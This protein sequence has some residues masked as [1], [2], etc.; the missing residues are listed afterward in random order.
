MSNIVTNPVPRTWANVADH[1]ARLADAINNIL[2][3]KLNNTGAVTLTA[4]AATTTLTDSR[5]GAE[6][7]IVLQATT[8]NAAG[9]V[10]TTYLD[11]PGNGSVVINHANNS[12]TDRTF[13]YAV[14]G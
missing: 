11:A 8:A 7:A 2:K 6:S 9:A 13:K 5:I 3:G 4:N 12:Q 10:A 14:I 1:V